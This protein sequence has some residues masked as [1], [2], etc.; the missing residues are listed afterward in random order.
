MNKMLSI[1]TAIVLFL[2]ITEVHA[3]FGMQPTQLY[4]DKQRS[5]SVNFEL[6]NERQ[7]RIFDVTAVKW[8]QNSKGEDVYIPDP[9]VL[10]NPKSFVIKAGKPQVVRVGFSKPVQTMNLKEEATWR[11]LFKEVPPVTDTT[12][13]KFLLNISIPLFVGPQQKANLSHKIEY[14]AN[15]SVL[16][17]KNNASSHIQIKEINLIDGGGKQVVRLADMKYLLASQQGEFNLGKVK[18]ESS[19]GYKLKILTDSQ[20]KPLEISL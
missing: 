1:V 9:D 8:S 2:N 14:R 18:V 6:T 12:S 20:E 13:V 7:S 4:I 10:I 15:Q 16:I 11:I 17:L 5:A 19:K 3:E